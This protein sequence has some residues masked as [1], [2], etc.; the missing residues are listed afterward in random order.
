M[1]IRSLLTGIAQIIGVLAVLAIIVTAFGLMLGI[2]MPADAFKRIGLI[3]G[4]VIALLIVP[5]VV[6][7][8]WSAIPVWQQIALVAIGL[9]ILLAFA[10]R[11]EK[12]SRHRE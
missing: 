8:T 10:T 1:I 3:V 2:L 7:C 11:R 9:V 4:T 6:V 5:Q 12:R